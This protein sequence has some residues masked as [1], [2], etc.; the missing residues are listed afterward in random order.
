M[1]DSDSLILFEF[2]IV[3]VFEK[4]N[5]SEDEILLVPETVFVSENV[6][7]SDED[8]EFDHDKLLVTVG[9]DN[10]TVSEIV[11]VLVTHPPQ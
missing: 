10:V 11:T 3:L 7:E 4:V 1:S 5:E 8:N 9:I 2:E 6:S